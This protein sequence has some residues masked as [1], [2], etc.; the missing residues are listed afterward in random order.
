VAAD[1]DEA[2]SRPPLAVPE[3]VAE[4]PPAPGTLA[5]PLAGEVATG[6][7]GAVLQ[8]VNTSRLQSHSLAQREDK[9]ADR[10]MG[11]DFRR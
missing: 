8:A 2:S 3:E 1:S 7:V 9:W 5:A 10:F 6:T 4:E 11:C